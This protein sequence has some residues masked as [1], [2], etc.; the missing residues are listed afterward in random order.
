[1]EASR[2]RSVERMASNDLN[3]PGQYFFREVW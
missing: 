1:V 2:V 3:I